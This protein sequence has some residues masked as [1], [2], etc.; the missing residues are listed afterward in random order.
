MQ[1]QRVSDV[2]SHLQALNTFSELQEEYY[3]PL[4]GAA[5]IL[6][7][8]MINDQM[9]MTQLRKFFGLLKKIQ[10]TH[11]GHKDD[12]PLKQDELYRMVPLLSYSYGRKI[13]SREFF[14]VMTVSLQPEKMPH[15]KDFNKFINFMEAVV[16]YYK[17]HERNKGG[18]RR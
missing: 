8:R 10:K 17:F 13:V 12:A 1:P 3:A 11:L 7:Q 9:K 15:V 5:D 6:A 2:K 16:A 4:G 14:D 18:E